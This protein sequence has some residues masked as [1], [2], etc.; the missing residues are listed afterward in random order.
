VSLGEFHER[1]VEVSVIG[2]VD[3]FVLFANDVTLELE[4]V[5]FHIIVL[6]LIDKGV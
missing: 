3:N 4:N 5:L 2:S 1:L 6:I